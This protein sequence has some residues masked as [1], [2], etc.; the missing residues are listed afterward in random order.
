[1]NAT[2]GAMIIGCAVLF[3][4]S[5]K[6]PREPRVGQAVTTGATGPTGS[7]ML[8]NDDAAMLLTNAR[9]QRESACDNIGAARRFLDP[10]ACRRSLFNESQATVSPE[11]CPVGVDETK[12]SLCLSSVRN[13]PCNDQELTPDDSP[14]CRRSELCEAP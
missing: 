1:M 10:D 9:C 8:M 12:L 11:A 7:R 14:A 5:C 6:S 2:V 13:Q 4:A 3:V